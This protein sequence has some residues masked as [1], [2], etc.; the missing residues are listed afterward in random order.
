MAIV[1]RKGS[2]LSHAAR[3]WLELTREVYGDG[4]GPSG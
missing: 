1:W 4:D 3:A 2:Y